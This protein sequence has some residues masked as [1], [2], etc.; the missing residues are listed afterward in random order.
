MLV[1]ALFPLFPTALA[2]EAD[3]W[4]FEE[5]ILYYYEDGIM[6]TSCIRQI[7]GLWFC[8]QADGAMLD[9]DCEAEILDE[10]GAVF[11][12][13]AMEG[14]EL[15]CDDC[16]TVPDSYPRIRYYY[17]SRGHALQGPVFME[18]EY[19]LFSEH[20]QLLINVDR[21]EWNEE[22]W[23]TDEYGR[24]LEGAGT[25]FDHE[26][27]DD[28]GNENGSGAGEA[29]ENPGENNQGEGQGGSGGSGESGGNGN[30]SG[31]GQGNAGGN[32]NGNQQQNPEPKNGWALEEDGTRYYVNDE[33]ISSSIIKIGELYYCFDENGLLLMNVS[34]GIYDQN[35][36]LRSIRAKSDGSL[37]CEESYQDPNA[38]SLYCY[39]AD[40]LS[41]YGFYTLSDGLRYFFSNGK[42]AAGVSFQ[43]GSDYYYADEYGNI[44]DGRFYDDEGNVL[45]SICVVSGDMLFGCYESGDAQR[46][47]G[48]GLFRNVYHYRA[49][50]LRDSVLVRNEFVEIGDSLYYF[51]NSGDLQTG[52]FYID[53][54][55]HL[56]AADGQYI[57]V[58]DSEGWNTI[59]GE[60]YYVRN[61]TLITEGE[62]T[63]DWK[64]CYFTENGMLLHDCLYGD[65]QLD[66]DGHRIEEGW[67]GRSE[68][69]YYVD[70]ETHTIVRD[71]EVSIE[72]QS[73]YFDA[74]GLMA[75]GIITVNG[76][77]RNYGTDGARIPLP[78]S[79]EEKTPPPSE[80]D[81]DQNYIPQ[82]EP[83]AK[84]TDEGNYRNGGSGH[85]GVTTATGNRPVS[86][87]EN[88]KPDSVKNTR[89]KLEPIPTQ[90]GLYVFR[91]GVWIHKNT[92]GWKNPLINISNNGKYAWFPN[93]GEQLRQTMIVTTESIL[94]FDETGLLSSNGVRRVGAHYC[95]IRCSDDYSGQTIAIF[96]Q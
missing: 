52:L 65:I 66:G 64:S 29:G 95:R 48:N 11:F 38:G 60:R 80:E 34:T 77:Q 33:A 17:D 63:V 20:G 19:Y 1:F 14:G 88:Q 71:R 54:T 86:T 6:L 50:Y 35:G 9:H 92:A 84:Q 16:Y 46:I 24:L 72:N 87:P 81:P 89:R 79:P 31:T 85:G 51:G 45:C 32:E 12:V 49:V 61:G 82:N 70:A 27:D 67:V 39:G 4:H 59:D 7:D 93:T 42:M 25:D 23:H 40:C 62:H 37:Y 15:Y 22:I 96:P 44:Q 18:E 28:D 13:R 43:H 90:P 68:G 47:V 91:Y 36:V 8:F 58:A 57:G 30:D 10:N 21:F 78:K 75:T 5:D 41:Y 56:S 3:G 83:M 74:D 94:Y 53:G 2:E 55:R 26:G 69:K 76:E 73:F